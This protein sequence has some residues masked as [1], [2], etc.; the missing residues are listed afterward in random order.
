MQASLD[1]SRI[2]ASLLTGA[3][4]ILVAGFP[5]PTFG[6]QS[7]EAEMLAQ[8]AQAAIASNQPDIAVSELQALLKLKSDDLNARASLGMVQ[9][10]QRRY[11][12]SADNFQ[13]V[14]KRSPELWNARA[15]LGMCEIRLGRPNAGQSLLV[16]TFPHL[17][18]RTLRKQTGLEL[19]N[20]YLSNGMPDKA[21]GI[22][23]E[24]E[25]GFSMDADVLYAVYRLH[26]EL[27]GAA[28][29]QLC[30]N[31]PDSAHF[32]QVLA[33][34]M[35]LQGDYPKSIDEYREALRRDPTLV[36]AHL[37]IGEAMLSAGKNSGTS[38]SAEEEFRAELAVNPG[39]PDALFQLGQIA[40]DRGDIER[41]RK[42][43]AES[44][45]ARPSFA[46]PHIALAK[47]YSDQNQ[48]TAAIAQ[49]ETAVNLAPDDR[50]AHY[51]LAQLYKKAGEGAKAAREFEIARQLGS[52]ENR[53]M[54]LSLSAT[55][56][57]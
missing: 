41:A 43:F 10:T 46:E 49:L 39:S 18:D 29:R 28:L 21:I 37:G 32:H 2:R 54:P 6:R 3:V 47:I 25:R 31:A 42:H 12:E 22:A 20:S 26:S 48:D 30:K 51:R 50:T 23:D 14:L 57:H 38:K 15:F 44:L 33:D 52:A 5:N 16:E 8:R 56:A 45:N 13:A 40:Y 27:A 1:S 24:L 7:S 35:L 53:A 9:F 55:A 17:T 36:G 34:A 4:L 11:Q 19:V